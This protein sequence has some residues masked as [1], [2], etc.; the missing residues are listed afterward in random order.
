MI[1]LRAD[2]TGFPLSRKWRGKEKAM[3]FAKTAPR[4]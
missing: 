1:V 2:Q 4:M 3:P